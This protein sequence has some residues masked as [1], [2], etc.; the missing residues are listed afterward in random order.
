MPELSN[1]AEDFQSG[2][3]EMERLL[4]RFEKAGCNSG[5]V[6]GG[7]MQALIFRMALGAPDTAT[8]LGFMGSCMSSAA[9]VL[10][11]KDD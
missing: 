5:A 8:V 2:V 6:M 1:E 11:E 3:E 9:Y 7:A 10:S 4:D